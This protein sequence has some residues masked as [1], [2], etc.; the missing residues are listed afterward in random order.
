MVGRNALQKL[1]LPYFLYLCNMNEQKRN[2]FKTTLSGLL[3]LAEEGI[4]RVKNR[5]WGKNTHP[6]PLEIIAYTGY[7]TPEHLYCRGRILQSK[8]IVTSAKDSPWRN[9]L[10]TYHRFESDEV[11]H[12]PLQIHYEGNTFL[13]QTD[14]EGYFKLDSSLSSSLQPSNNIWHNARF[15]LPAAVANTQQHQTVS[16]Y[17]QMLV[18]NHLADYG[19]ISDLDDTLIKSNIISK[20]KMLYLALFKNAYTRLAFRGAPALYWALRKGKN[21]SS[22]NPI[23]YVSNSPWNLYDMLDEFMDIN[24]IPKGPILLRDFGHAG[25]DELSAA[26]KQ[27]KYNETVKILETYPNL[28]FILIGDSGEKD[29]DTYLQVARQF[30]G[31]ILCIYI[32]AVNDKK[33]AQR[34]Q[35]LAKA[36]TNMLLIEDSLDI[37]KHAQLNGFIHKQGLHLVNQ[38]LYIDRSSLVDFWLEEE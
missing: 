16:A 1:Y 21:G 28:P 22:K 7:G 5:K 27:H 17:S 29:A 8:G 25:N 36:E 18:P 2:G 30:P 37:A 20:T 10:N 33:R 4:D 11:P 15:D 19:V 6:S 14:E 24:H 23:F 26:F 35:Q 12:H 9:L 34:V 31:R 38:S 13:L 32:R 3:T